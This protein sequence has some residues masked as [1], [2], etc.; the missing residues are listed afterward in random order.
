MNFLFSS[1]K[2]SSSPEETQQE[3]ITTKS[4]PSLSDTSSRHSNTSAE[5]W[6]RRIYS[7]QS[8]RC[9]PQMRLQHQQQQQA[10]QARKKRIETSCKSARRLETANYLSS[11]SN[12]CTLQTFS[13]LMMSSA[14]GAGD[15][16]N[17]I[18]KRV[19]P[20]TTERAQKIQQSCQRRS[21]ED[22][23][24]NNENEDEDLLSLTSELKQEM[25]G[26]S[27]SSPAL[28]TSI[29]TFGDMSSSERQQATSS[30]NSELNILLKQ[31]EVEPTDDVELT[32]KFALFESI[33][34]TV[35]VI[36]DQTLEFWNENNDLFEGGMRMA[37][38]REVDKMDAEDC[39]GIVDD[40]RRWFVY[41]MTK[42]AND[43]SVKIAE[44]LSLLRSRLEQINTLDVGECPFCL[45]DMGPLKDQNMTTVLSCCHRVCKPCWE[46]WQQVKGPHAF[47]PLCRS[48]E[49]VAEVLSSPLAG[50]GAR[51]HN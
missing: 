51:G 37:A 7:L 15:S 23:G 32:A 47:C 24:G 12:M 4:S 21:V 36:R 14:T 39:L 25:Q 10:K 48:D 38:Q 29:E 13:P 11:A 31:L 22:N 28:M 3:P 42:K 16:R 20:K 34:Q 50:A 1:S 27:L 5:E 45:D 17:E 44:I 40:P 43:N 9:T 49:F 19:T 46:Q 33:L 6:Q 41:G 18:Y 26:M 35:T 30:I 8:E 2:A